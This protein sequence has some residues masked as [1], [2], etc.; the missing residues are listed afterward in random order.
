MEEWETDNFMRGATNFKIQYQ[1]ED[2]ICLPYS[3]SPNGISLTDYKI[4]VNRET[5]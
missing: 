3:I 4:T 1:I 2:G 5:G